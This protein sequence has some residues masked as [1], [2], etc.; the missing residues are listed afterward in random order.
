[1]TALAVEPRAEDRHQRDD[2]AGELRLE[3]HART[4]FKNFEAGVRMAT[5]EPHQVDAEPEQ[6]VLMNDP[7]DVEA[8][9]KNA[10]EEL[11]KTGLAAVQT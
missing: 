4:Y 2:V 10:T 3:A 11:P 9:L 1:M 6:A 5:D 7:D 8:P